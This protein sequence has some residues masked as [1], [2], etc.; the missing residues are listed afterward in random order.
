MAAPTTSFFGWFTREGRLRNE[1]ARA[2]KESDPDRGL[3]QLLK[4]CQQL[5][6]EPDRHGHLWL[7]FLDTCVTANRAQ[8][9]TEPDFQIFQ[10]MGDAAARAK[11][12]VRAIDVWTRVLKARD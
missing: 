2:L 10:Q 8:H 12:G 11:A 7:P 9:M 5:A 1:W 6:A 4:V 3:Q